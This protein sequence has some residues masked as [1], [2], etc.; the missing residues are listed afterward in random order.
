MYFFYFGVITGAFIFIMRTSLPNRTEIFIG[1]QMGNR[2]VFHT[3]KL[4]KRTNDYFPFNSEKGYYTNVIN[5]L[6]SI[7]HFAFENPAL[8]FNEDNA[9]PL[10][11]NVPD[12]NISD[13]E[14]KQKVLEFNKKVEEWKANKGTMTKPD[15]KP[16]AFKI[17]AMW[18]ASA[19]AFRSYFHDKMIWTSWQAIISRGLT[20]NY[21]QL[22]IGMGIGGLIVFSLMTNIG[23]LHFGSST[24]SSITSSISSS[25]STQL[26]IG[27]NSTSV[28][29]TST[30][31]SVSTT[32]INGTT[33]TIHGI[34]PHLKPRK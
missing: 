16:I 33:Y 1:K 25:I 3:H 10:Q 34:L 6:I 9:F 13:E 4:I 12:M 19:T 28:A 18:I 29:T 8:F 31:S 30:T 32:V 27:N 17:H 7:K 14:Y 2:I 21:T 22:L 20:S 24:T 15:G 5:S 26:T 11:M 23:L